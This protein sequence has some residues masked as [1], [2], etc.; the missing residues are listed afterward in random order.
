MSIYE[1]KCVD[2][3]G[4]ETSLKVSSDMETVEDLEEVLEKLFKFFLKTGAV[5]PEELQEYFENL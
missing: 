1:I 3:D 5:L 4:I 2:E